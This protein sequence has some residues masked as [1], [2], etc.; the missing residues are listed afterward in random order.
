M[1]INYYNSY[2]SDSVPFERIPTDYTKMKWSSGLMEKYNR[3]TYLSSNKQ[4]TVTTLLRPF[5]KA[6]L[7]NNKELIERYYRNNLLFPNESSNNLVMVVSGPGALSGF[8]V[9]LSDKIVNRSAISPAECFPFY[10]YNQASKGNSELLKNNLSNKIEAK[11]GITSSGTQYFRDVYSNEQISK[12]DLF[13]YIYGL[14]HSTGYRERFANNLVN[15]LPRIPAVKNFDDFLE[16]S[17]AGRKLG[18]LHVNYE[19]VDCYPISVKE[20][21]LRLLAPHVNPNEFFRVRKMRFGN[22]SGKQDKTTVIYNNN[23]TMT[24]IPLEAYDYVISGKPALKWVMD[25]QCVHFDKKSGITSDA[26]DYANEVMK[27]PAYL[28]KLFQR[29]ITVSLETMK[30]VRNLPNLDID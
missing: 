29:V 4:S 8:S 25:Q 16:F 11:D 14:L 19:N 17:N 1:L 12:E 21:D 13:Y 22:Q 15:E 18:N 23:I 6:I 26:N 2:L 20:G 24:N 9:F 30:I 3:G 10:V 27:D 5:T 28:M 7:V